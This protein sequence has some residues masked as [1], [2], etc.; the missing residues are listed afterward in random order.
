MAGVRIEVET[1][2]AALQASFRRL[3]AT[4]DDL[5]PVMDEIGQSLV[6]S[7]IDR[8]ERERGPGGGPWKPSARAT[9][10]K[11]GRGQ[12]LTDTGR[13]RASITHRAGRDAVEVGTNVAYAAIHQFGG[14]IERRARNQVLAFRARGGGFASRKST[15][16]RKA[17]AVR[18]AFAQIGAHSIDM[19]ARPFL[20]IDEDDRASILRIVSRAIERTVQ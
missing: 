16:A 10:G 15:R 2:D 9:R 13:L 14:Q 18:V 3:T 4:L 7:V 12:T 6:A 8:F 11:R 5:R 17:G 19:P 20:G 1:D